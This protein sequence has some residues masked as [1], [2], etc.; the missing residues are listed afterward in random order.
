M[1]SEREKKEILEDAQNKSRRQ[2]F[3]FAKEKHT[4]AISF[5]EYLVFL[6]NLQQIFSPFVVSQHKTITRFNKL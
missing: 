2:N 4:A 5:E 3:R 6:D 1:L